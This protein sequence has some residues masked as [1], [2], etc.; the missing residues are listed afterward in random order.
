MPQTRATLHQ[1]LYTYAQFKPTILPTILTNR[2][3]VTLNPNNTQKLQ[4]TLLAILSLNRSQPKHLTFKGT[5]KFHNIFQLSK[6]MSAL[7]KIIFLKDLNE[8]LS[9]LNIV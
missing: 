5:G 6:L 3:D 1:I 8:N 9:L 2:A 4:P 7:A